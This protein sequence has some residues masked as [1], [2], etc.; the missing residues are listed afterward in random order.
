MQYINTGPS[1]A[2]FAFTLRVQVYNHSL[3][4][5]CETVIPFWKSRTDPPPPI[6]LEFQSINPQ[7]PFGNSR[8]PPYG[9]DIFGNHPVGK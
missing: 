8:C 2:L 9:M 7:P 3:C 1:G 6:H 4:L 5:I